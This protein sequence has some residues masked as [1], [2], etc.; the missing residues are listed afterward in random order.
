MEEQTGQSSPDRGRRRRPLRWV[1]TSLLLVA[2]VVAGL[3]LWKRTHHTEADEGCTVTPA[4]GKPVTMDLDQGS[5]A[6]TIAAVTL[7]RGMPE[8]ALTI[9]LAT[10]LQESKLRNL[11]GGDRDSIGLFQQ[12]PSMG[13]GTPQQ[14][15]DP[16]YASQK[17]L[18]ALKKEAPNYARM[19]LTEAAQT[20]QKSGYPGAYA[21]HEAKASLLASA[22]TG[23][24]PATF[25]CVVHSFAEP[26][27]TDPAAAGT[28][29]GTT[30]AAPAAATAGS[31][32]ASASPSGAPAT[33]P[34]SPK[35][36][37]DRLKR[38]FGRAVTAAAGPTS[39]DART[40]TLALT[41]DPAANTDTGPD[42]QRQSG[43]AV[44]EWSVAHAQELGIG[45]IHFDGKAWR[46]D[47]SDAGWTAQPDP[48]ATDRVLVTLGMPAAKH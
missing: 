33:G 12:R 45:T 44:A 42:A 16:V 5:N 25:S 27:P 31:G 29:A 26:D 35:Q 15:Q 9:A 39:S 47:R 18:D 20:V 36:L 8:R 23:R 30:A 34:G 38:E 43:W 7:S 22:L 10:A 48:A 32:S 37:T 14:I 11:E 24:A 2:A 21:K 40:S 17:F 4:G 41:P 28:T 3:V 1:L 6:A 19:P 13:W 46:M